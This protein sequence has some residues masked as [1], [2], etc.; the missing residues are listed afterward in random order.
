M[1]DAGSSLG[2]SV[3]AS[4]PIVLPSE[5]PH[6]SVGKIAEMWDLSENAVR[7]MFQ[8]YPGV[9]HVGAGKRD[10]LRIPA[11]VLRRFHEERS[12]GLRR[13]VKRSGR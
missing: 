1:A 6:Y 12:R 4:N 10:V 8:D 2:G 9:L 7:R 3:M 13:E 11:S 5:E